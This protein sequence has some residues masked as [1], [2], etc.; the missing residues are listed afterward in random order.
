MLVLDDHVEIRRSHH[1]RYMELLKDIKG[2]QV[3][4]RPSAEYDTNYWLTCIEVDP[5]IAGFSREDVRLALEE[6]ILRVV[7][8][9]NRCTYSLFMLMRLFTEMASLKNCLKKDYVCLP[10]HH[11]VMMI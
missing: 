11:L 9:G 4:E 5:D 3:K 7:H 8:Y 1:A 6:D 2:L 10:V